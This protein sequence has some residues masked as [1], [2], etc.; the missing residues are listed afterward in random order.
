MPEQTWSGRDPTPAT[1]HTTDQQAQDDRRR[2][3]PGAWAIALMALA[4]VLVGGCGS[5]VASASG[6]PTGGDIA[7]L[8]SATINEPLAQLTPAATMI[9][10]DAAKAS[11]GPGA[12]PDADSTVVVGTV[13]GTFRTTLPLT[14]RRADGSPEHGLQQGTLID[15]NLSAVAD[16]VEGLHQT[17]PGGLNLLDGLDQIAT[18]S[19][20][21]TLI[22]ISNGLSTKGG[23][24]YRAVGWN[25]DP[26]TIVDQLAQGG[27][28]PDLHG[29]RVLWLGLN[30]TAGE[31]PSL[32]KPFRDA[33]ERYWSA[34]CAASG[35]VSCSFDDTTLSPEPPVST[36]DS[37]IVTVPSISSVPGSPR[38]LKLVIPDA[39]LGFSGNSAALPPS[40]SDAIGEV[41]ESIDSFKAKHA[42]SQF[43]ITVTGYAADPPGSG[44]PDRMT[45]ST[46]RA[47]ACADALRSAGVAEDIS[48]IG[49]GAA[50]GM[51]SIRDGVFVESQAEP[52]RRVELEVTANS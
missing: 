19:P 34:I 37:P 28:L 41:V 38:T 23:L 18:G 42:G 31:Q 24:D 43:S 32:P 49:G 26:Q 16:T 39:V 6:P 25:S 33:N 47:R 48:V 50:P 9:L 51:T 13:D 15:K 45:L 29:W 17:T 10:A 4:S 27:L 36:V 14:P 12:G 44:P 5:P 30:A 40:S 3:P 52:M 1:E 8:A 21:G 7:I 46:E 35:A 11:V 2:Q 20:P 22:V